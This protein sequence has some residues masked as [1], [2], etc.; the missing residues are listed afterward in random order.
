MNSGRSR[1]VRNWASIRRKGSAPKWSPCRCE[2]TM[3]STSFGSRPCALRATSDDAPQSTSSLPFAVSRKKQV[4]NRPPE[5][6]ASPDPMIVRRMVKPT[7][8]FVDEVTSPL[9]IEVCLQFW[10][11]ACTR[12]SFDQYTSCSDWHSPFLDFAHHEFL[13]IFRRPTFR[14]ND[15]GPQG[16]ET[17]LH[18]QSIQRRNDRLVELADDWLRRALRHKQA[19]PVGCFKVCETLLLS[20]GQIWQ[21]RQASLSERGDAFHF[22]ILDQRYHGPRERALIVDTTGDHVLRQRSDVAVRHMGDFHSDG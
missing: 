15:C 16:S 2:S 12:S 7:R 1:R 5:P 13:Q 4:L 18:G 6:K 14:S 17:L 9:A 20:A 8:D 3:P 11:P 10:G 19:I 21:D 22:I